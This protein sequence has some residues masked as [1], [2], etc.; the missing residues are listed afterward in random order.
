MERQV[1]LLN[2]AGLHARAAALFVQEASKYKSDIKLTDGEKD[3][4]AKSILSVI[5]FGAEEGA[6]FKITA[7]GEDAEKALDGLEKLLNDK[8]FVEA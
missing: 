6:V 4:N 7:E 1:K 3:A 8:E 2:R 5:S